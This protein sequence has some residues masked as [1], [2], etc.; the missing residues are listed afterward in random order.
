MIDLLKQYYKK[1]NIKKAKRV[2]LLIFWGAM[3]GFWLEL[4][5][6]VNGWLAIRDLLLFN[7]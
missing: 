5:L 3:A 7:I 1:E 2:G 6:W 4:V